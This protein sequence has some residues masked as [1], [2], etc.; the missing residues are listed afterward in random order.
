MWFSEILE[1][2]AEESMA[3]MPN[4]SVAMSFSVETTFHPKPFAFH[5]SWKHMSEANL[6]VLI[7]HCPEILA[8]R[9]R[10]NYSA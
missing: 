7:E 4:V 6:A 8:L 5:A 3:V 10:K 1:K 9:P 2:M